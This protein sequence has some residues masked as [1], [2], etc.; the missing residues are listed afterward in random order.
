MDRP[1]FVGREAE[2]KTLQQA[3]DDVVACHPGSSF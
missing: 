2:I 3:W 1:P